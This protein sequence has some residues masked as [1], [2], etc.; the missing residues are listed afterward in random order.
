MIPFKLPAPRG[1]SEE[2]IWNGAEFV[3]GGATLPILE[4]SEN[5]E[6][7]SDDLTLLHEEAA[8]ENHPI[9][10]ASRMHAVAEIRKH[11]PAGNGVVM[12]IGCSSGFLL[13]DLV[14]EFPGCSTIGADVVKE[15][16]LKLHKKLG[17]IPLIR[18]DLLQCPLPAGSVDVI[19]MLN[20]FEHIDNDVLAMQQAFNLL[21]PGGTLVVEV[22]AGPSLF[23]PYDVE[24]N[25]FRRYTRKELDSKLTSVGF[26]VVTRSHL[27][28]L[29]FPMFALVKLKDKIFAANGSKTGVRGHASSTKDNSLMKIMMAVETRFF[30]RL[31]LPFGIRVLAT[32]VKSATSNVG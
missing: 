9:D 1:Y 16:L 23:G 2:P 17:A 24:L 15:P 11:L 7:W 12:D 20:V 22:P 5:F 8:G 6:G 19:V 28:F 4:Y 27:G 3:I 10:V 31:S 32:A 14:R 18:F 13:N 25:H 26:D 29:L 21:K 30:S